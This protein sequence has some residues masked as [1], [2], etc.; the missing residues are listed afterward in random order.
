M[1]IRV[2]I[3]PGD[4]IVEVELVGDEKKRGITVVELLKRLGISPEQAIVA[5]EEEFVLFNNDVLED[6][7]EVTVYLSTSTG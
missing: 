4:R 2:K 7:D 6:G 5:F 3:K 1:P